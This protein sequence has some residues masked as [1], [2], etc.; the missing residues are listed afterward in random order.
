MAFVTTGYN[1]RQNVVSVKI[2]GIKEI[3]K[4]LDLLA[5][6]IERRLLIDVMK[7]SLLK[8]KAEAE[9]RAPTGPVVVRTGK[10]GG[11]YS[12]I[13]GRLK[14]SFRIK[15]MRSDNPFMLEVQ[16]QNTA[17]YA[18]W[19]EYGHRIVRGRKGNKRVVGSARARPFMRPTFESTKGA[20]QNEVTN[21]LKL[22][23]ARRGV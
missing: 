17:Y 23:L 11:R 14:R 22:A 8:A 3:Q 16:L 13:P 6:H 12:N 4:R 18:L 19:V 1:S 21:E 9:A 5:D 10:T 20:I 7:K 2:E 15:K